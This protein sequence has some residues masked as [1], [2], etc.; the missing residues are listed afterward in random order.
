MVIKNS[1]PLNEG[2]LEDFESRKVGGERVSDEQIR[3]DLTQ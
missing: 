3:G 1:V 2:G